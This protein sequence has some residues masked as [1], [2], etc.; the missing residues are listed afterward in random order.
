M[1]HP[2]LLRGSSS[3]H[4]PNV[5]KKPLVLVRRLSEVLR[6]IKESLHHSTNTS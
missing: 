6:D 5:E 4:S 1:V 2:Q 3:S